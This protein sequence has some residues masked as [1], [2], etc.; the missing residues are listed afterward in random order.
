[1]S[2]KELLVDVEVMVN[3]DSMRRGQVGQ[4]ELSPRI[5]ALVDRGYL[6]I[7]GHAAPAPEAPPSSVKLSPLATGEAESPAPTEAPAVRTR[8]SRAKRTVPTATPE[9]SGGDSA[10]DAVLE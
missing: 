6:K 10:S 4:V 8:P 5:Q 3:V 9:V 7:L 1:M 2:D